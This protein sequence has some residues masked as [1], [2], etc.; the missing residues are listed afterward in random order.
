MLPA[1]VPSSRTPRTLVGRDRLA[2]ERCVAAGSEAG[3]GGAVGD[4]Q[5][6]RRPFGGD[7]RA[8]QAG[9]TW[10]PSQ[11]NLRGDFVGLQHGAGE[12]R[13]AMVQRRHAVEQM[14][15]VPRAGGDR[16]ERLF[17][18]RRRVAERHA[19]SARREPA[20]EIETAVELGRQRHDADVGRRARDLGEHV[21]RREY[22]SRRR[23]ARA[24][25]RTESIGA[26][27]AGRPRGCAPR[28]PG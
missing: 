26:A 10:T 11:I 21:G 7:R 19:V 17:V 3:G 2:A 27:A 22:R 24:A 15:R 28:I 9:W 1:R 6:A 14:R 8:E 16:R 20:N 4:R 13:R 25:T 18:G 5:D 23:S 12:A